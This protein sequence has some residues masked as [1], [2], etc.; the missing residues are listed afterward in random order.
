MIS[1]GPSMGANLSV[2]PASKLN[3]HVLKV[4]LY[5]MSK[6]ELFWHIVRLKVANSRFYTYNFKHNP[7]IQTYTSTIVKI[8][9]K[10]SRPVD[11][12]ARIFGQTPIAVK[13]K[14]KALKVI[15]GFAEFKKESALLEKKIY[16][17]D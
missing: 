15:V 5:K 11:A 9:S 13:V 4:T 8:T 2:A 10:K 1:N 3:D 16:L 6:K 17:G 12:D 7:D 14:P